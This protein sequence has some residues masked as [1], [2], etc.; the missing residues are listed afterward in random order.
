M[1][2]EVD[3]VDYDTRGTTYNVTVRATDAQGL[4]TEE[5][6]TVTVE[7]TTAPSFSVDDQTIE[8]G[9]FSNVDWTTYIYNINENTDEGTTSIEISDGVDY[10]T[11]GSY[12]VTLRVT[13]AEGL[14][15]EETFTVT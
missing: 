4:F 10:D 3:T 7:D 12:S 1:G 8:A 6:F 11:T 13:D 9:A 2:E 14:F 5:S 15:S